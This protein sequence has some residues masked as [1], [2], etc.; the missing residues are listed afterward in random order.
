MAYESVADAADPRLRD[1]L[2]LTDTSLRRT[3][4]PVEGLFVAEGEKVVRRA[5]AAGYRLRSVLL[6]PRWVDPLRDLL[7]GLDVPVLVA[8]DV[9]LRQVTGY[10]VHRGALASVHRPPERT[11]ADV[12]T[13]SRRVAVLEGFVDPTNVGAVFRCA[14][15]LGLD[16]VLLDPR[17]ADPLYRRSVKVSM[18]A[19]L[20]LPYARLS[21]WP[22]ALATVRAAGLVVV[23]LTPSPDA[24]AL[25]DLAAADARRCALLLGSE[26]TG[27]SAAALALAD[28]RV[29]IPMHRGVDSLNVAAAA[30]V[31]FWSV[32][33]GACR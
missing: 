33:G 26:G 20:E 31:A 18:G 30:A 13:G 29:R 3:L 25:G 15:A 7:D 24:A 16:A 27:L 21:P 11:A 10:H 6:S 5:V 2:A 14:A 17:C 4:E 1:Y 12:L 28:R 8:D 32:T 9:L 23:A 19:V 22:S